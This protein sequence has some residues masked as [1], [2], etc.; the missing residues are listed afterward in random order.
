MVE[1]LNE[2]VIKGDTVEILCYGKNKEFSR[3]VLI[4]LEDLELVSSVPNAW[5]IRGEIGKT[6]YAVTTLNGEQVGMHRF[7]LNP[8]EGLVT[9]HRTVGNGLDNRRHNLRAVTHRENAWNIS[10]KS[11]TGE[12]CISRYYSK[13]RVR[14]GIGGN[15]VKHVGSFNTIEEA[16]Q[17]RDKFIE[18]LNKD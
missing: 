16:I 7:I 9:D 4:D 10:R 2:Y 14:V 5:R 11:S 13:Y 1:V 18:E 3:V 12:R 17:A 8:P 15:K 6:M